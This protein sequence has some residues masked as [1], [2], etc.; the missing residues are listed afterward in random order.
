MHVGCCWKP[1]AGKL[2]WLL[3]FVSF[4]GGL[5]ALYLGGEFWNVSVM[6]WYWTALVG[7]VLSFGLKGKHGW[8]RCGTCGGMSCKDGGEK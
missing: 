3:S 6:T 8:C 2:L 4:L 7:G 5:F 1:M